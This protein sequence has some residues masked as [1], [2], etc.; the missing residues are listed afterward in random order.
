V[1][2]DGK[3]L[4]KDVPV[5]HLLFLEKKLVEIKEFISKLPVLETTA[6]WV[7]DAGSNLWMTPA[8]ETAKTK[9][10]KHYETVVPP[11]KE[12]PAQVKEHD[13]D[14]IQGYWITTQYS[15][16]L[17]HKR[18]KELAGRADTL[19]R[20]VKIAREEANIHEIVEPEKTGETIIKFVFGA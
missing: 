3:I 16:A 4:L 9:K 1:V 15:G 13:V 10:T 12:H 8:V 11:T 7:E 14:V 19:Y 20:A 5:P 6:E 18:V 17:P 2:V